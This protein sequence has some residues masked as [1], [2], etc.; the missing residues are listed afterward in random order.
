MGIHSKQPKKIY[1]Y[2]NKWR[3]RERQTIRDWQYHDINEILYR[4][5]KTPIFHIMRYIQK[6]KIIYIFMKMKIERETIKFEICN[7]M[8]LM[9]YYIVKKRKTIFHIIRYI[10]N[11]IN[12]LYIYI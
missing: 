11:S 1:I 3:L 12:D 4:Q 9:K 2:I 7:F 6:R 5:K 8:I 10:Q